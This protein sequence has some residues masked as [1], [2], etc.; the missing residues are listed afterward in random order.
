MARRGSAIGRLQ[1][2]RPIG[3][4]KYL[5]GHRF[6]TPDDIDAIIEAVGLPLA[7]GTVE[8]KT[9]EADQVV[10]IK[11][12]RRDALLDRIENAAQNWA[13]NINWQA[14]PNPRDEFDAYS[15]IVEAA[16]KLLSTLGVGP[17]G[18]HD[19]AARKWF[20]ACHA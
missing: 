15:D 19:L 3:I 5:D 10:T 16:D 1:R 9:I 4:E 17:G 12:E 18:D 14:K 20:C 13:V 11:V 6:F 2:W 8:H 7:G